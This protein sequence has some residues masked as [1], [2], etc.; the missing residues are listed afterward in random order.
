MI[1]LTRLPEESKPSARS[2]KVRQTWL[3]PSDYAS[4]DIN[5]LYLRHSVHPIILCSFCLSRD[6]SLKMLLKAAATDA[7]K[8]L[9]TIMQNGLCSSIKRGLRKIEIRLTL[10]VCLKNQSNPIGF[11]KWARHGHT[12]PTIPPQTS[13]CFAFDIVHLLMLCSFCL[14][15]G[16][17]LK[18]LLKAATTDAEDFLSTIVRNGSCAL[19]SITACARSRYDFPYEVAKNGQSNLLG[20]TK[21]TTH[22]HTLPT[23][24]PQTSM[25]FAFD[26]VHFIILCRFL[27]RS[28]S[29]K[30]SLKAAP[31]GSD[32]FWSIPLYRTV[33]AVQSSTACARLR[34]EYPYMIA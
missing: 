10:Q 32:E 16:V 8:F 4:T 15:R 33:G 30:P 17:S 19:Q 31:A 2:H 29:L 3:Y 26:I 23:I 1:I 18:M 22:G 6:E 13:M 9:S 34:C 20:F 7:D 25:S 21:W 24:P 5:V 14:S 27:S 28:V 12:L 11:T